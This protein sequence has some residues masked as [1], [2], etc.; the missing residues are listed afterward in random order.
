MSRR[1]TAFSAILLA[2]ALLLGAAAFVW[3]NG[4]GGAGAEEAE[5]VVPITLYMDDDAYA[6]TAAALDN[7]P[8]TRTLVFENYNGDE[9]LD[10]QMVEYTYQALSSWTTSCRIVLRT[11][12]DDIP[13]LFGHPEMSY[14]EFKAEF[15]AVKDG[16]K[17]MWNA[18]SKRVWTKVRQRMG[19]KYLDYAGV[20]SWWDNG[21]SIEYAEGGT[22][23][24]YTEY[25]M[26]IR[27]R[28]ITGYRDGVDDQRKVRQYVEELFNEGGEFYNYRYDKDYATDF[29][30]RLVMWH[31][32]RRAK[33]SWLPQQSIARGLWGDGMACDAYS[34]F[35]LLLGHWLGLDVNGITG[36]YGQIGHEWNSIRIGRYWYAM[37]NT[38]SADADPDGWNLA[39]STDEWYNSQYKEQGA[40]EI[41]EYRAAHQRWENSYRTE[42]ANGNVIDSGRINTLEGGQLTWTLD[43]GILRITGEGTM[44]D[45]V[46]ENEVPWRSYVGN[47]KGIE[48]AST[49]KN[50]G[51]NAFAACMG[52]TSKSESVVLPHGIK[53]GEA[54][55]SDLKT[56]SATGM[57]YLRLSGTGISY[58]GRALTF[59]ELVATAAYGSANAAQS[60]VTF[61]YRTAGEEGEKFV[62]GTPE[63]AG[64]YEVYGVIRAKSVN[65]VSYSEYTSQSVTVVI[66]PCEIHIVSITLEND[67]K[68]YDGTDDAVIKYVGFN[69]S[70]Y[71]TYDSAKR[72]QLGR[73]FTVTGRYASSQVKHNSS[74]GSAGIQDV[75]IKEITMLDTLPGKNYKIAY[76]S[77]PVGSYVERIVHKPLAKEMFES[78]PAQRW[79]GSQIKPAVMIAESERAILFPSDFT[80]TYGENTDEGKGYVYITSNYAT[81][82]YEGNITLEFDI[83]KTAAEAAAPTLVLKDNPSYVYDGYALSNE[84][85]I[86]TALYG[87]TAPVSGDISISYRTAGSTDEF[88]AGTPINVGSYE[89]QAS[90][91]AR[92]AGGKNYAART[93]RMTVTITK[94]SL[95]ITPNDQTAVYSYNYDLPSFTAV[96]S[97]LQGKDTSG[98]VGNIMFAIENYWMGQPAGK[99][100]ISAK[101]TTE[102]PK[103]GNYD[104]TYIYGTF[105]ATPREV[106]L[107]WENT[108]GRTAGDGK[109]VTATAGNIYSKGSDSVQV[110]VEGGDINTPGT[111]TA[112]AV[113]LTGNGATNYKLPAN[114]SVEYV[115]PAPQGG[116]SASMDSSYTY[117]E[118][119]QVQVYVPAASG[120]VTLIAQT[121]YGDITLASQEVSETVFT[122]TY[123]TKQKLLLPGEYTFKVKYASGDESAE[124][125]L[126]S[127]LTA[128]T[129]TVSKTSS[130]PAIRGALGGDLSLLTL[131]Y[132]K[133]GTTFYDI[134]L[135]DKDGITS[136]FYTLDKRVI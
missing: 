9:S 53:L 16:V 114:A 22:S 96:W 43:G 26:L 47:I 125:T 85:I 75:Y 18:I 97:G 74:N 31:I 127:A 71:P 51:A 88:T 134:R 69:T 109:K 89:V 102:G 36:K 90:M 1:I 42:L 82:N 94:A 111:H 11:N 132:K 13:A 126:Q 110:V 73:D 23:Y 79:T 104:I 67:I 37:D 38:G 121:Q 77:S 4:V 59:D 6:W 117:G 108:E 105:I 30:K 103:I 45:F 25:T 7:P 41:P 72:L 122:L 124:Y 49:V 118:Q 17:N 101:I 33:Y 34:D 50:V 2:A 70:E 95:T 12:H 66:S 100:N 93:E 61:F 133:T 112:T 123:D 129:L 87:T 128:R 115:I 63:N 27:S 92:A 44:R 5:E 24:D 3:V 81:G 20:H 136:A 39:G 113:S 135:H 10:E 21:Y 84:E 68:T 64:T 56:E 29:E 107:K 120:S 35:S 62:Q 52:V 15:N 86:Q 40:E 130:A 99:Y 48:I 46:T 106:S 28:Y 54:A 57:A 83:S 32:T 14:E 119:M 76:N 55:F 8:A 98:E 58:Q 80:V 116:M 19:D 131:T 65:G 60:D 91:R 78:I